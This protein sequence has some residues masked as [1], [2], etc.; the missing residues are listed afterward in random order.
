ME[1]IAVASG[2]R[3]MVYDDIEADGIRLP[4]RRRAYTRGAD[5]RPKLHP[6]MF[7]IDIGEVRL[8]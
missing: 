1:L 3:Q 8:S 4:S 6:L 7:S 2:Y 5:L